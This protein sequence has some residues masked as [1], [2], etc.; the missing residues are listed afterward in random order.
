MPEIV[1]WFDPM[2][3]ADWANWIFLAQAHIMRHFDL[4][5]DWAGGMASGGRL[6]GTKYLTL[7]TRWPDAT[8]RTATAGRARARRLAAVFRR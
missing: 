8:S 7:A 5:D 1:I 2:P 4:G 3:A 6:V